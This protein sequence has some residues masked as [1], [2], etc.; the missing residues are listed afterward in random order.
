MMKKHQNFVKSFDEMCSA[1]PYCQIYFFQVLHNSV[2]FDRLKEHAPMHFVREGKK[3]I[4]FGAVDEIA[5]S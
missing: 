5:G 1:K 4:C 3:M 2:Y